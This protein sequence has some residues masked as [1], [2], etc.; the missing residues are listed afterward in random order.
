MEVLIEFEQNMVYP[1]TLLDTKLLKLTLPNNDH[2]FVRGLVNGTIQHMNSIDWIINNYSM[3]RKVTD[4][5]KEV[6]NSLRVAVYQLEYMRG[7]VP[8]Y[9]AVDQAVEIVKLLG[10][11]TGLTG[12]TNGVLRAIVRECIAGRNL[13]NLSST[14]K[15]VVKNI[16]LK[17]SHPEWMV[18]R[19]LTQYGIDDT[20][21]LCEV[22]NT[23]ADMAVRVNTLKTTSGEVVTALNNYGLGVRM[24]EL[25]PDALVFTSG[26]PFLEGL[27]EFQAGMF[28]IQDEAS[29]LV[30]HILGPQPGEVVYD[31]CSAPGGK[32]THAAQLMKNSGKI[33]AFD[34]FSHKLRFIRENSAR[35]GVTIIDPQLRDGENPQNFTG[36]VDRVLIDV[37]CSGT[38]VLRRRPDL[39]WRRTSNDIIFK[40]PKI[41]YS[42]LSNAAPLVK[43]GGILVYSTCSIEPEENEGVIGK[44][45]KEFPLFEIE[46]I[47]DTGKFLGNKDIVNPGGWVQTLTH[48]HGIDGFFVIRFR[49]KG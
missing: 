47:R 8:P 17:H 39:K 46:N 29:Q 1:K 45:V 38:G 42:I 14:G 2:G 41:Q 10:G 15:D 5:T 18:Q 4:T 22:N 25:V 48:K 31:I 36:A 16:S 35:L 24:S 7:R 32:A 28:Y 9:A 44:F 33:V 21:K 19:W 11:H 23:H 3:T 30:T 37:P 20:E 13:L 12:Y 34:M 6:R 43:P 40:L 49:R 27:A 26:E